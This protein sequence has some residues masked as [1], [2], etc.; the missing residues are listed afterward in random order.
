MRKENR[1]MFA[2][3][4]HDGDVKYSKAFAIGIPFS[5]IVFPSYAINHTYD[6]F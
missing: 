2:Q 6:S 1:K 5:N 3:E 4:K